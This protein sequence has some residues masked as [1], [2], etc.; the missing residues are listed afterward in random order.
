VA[1]KSGEMAVITTPDKIAVAGRV[2]IGSDS[3]F[4]AKVYAGSMTVEFM[5]SISKDDSVNGVYYESKSASQGDTAKFEHAIKL[6]QSEKLIVSSSGKIVYKGMFAADDVD[7]KESW[8][9]WNKARD[10]NR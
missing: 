3:T 6:Y 2:S 1:L 5:G 4:E 8:V 9:G 7:E 10:A